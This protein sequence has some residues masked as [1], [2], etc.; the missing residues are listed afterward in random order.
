MDNTCNV[1]NS[2][3][4]RVAKDDYEI[5]FYTVSNGNYD[6]VQRLCRRLVD[7]EM[8]D[9]LFTAEEVRAAIVNHGQS[10]KRFKLGETIQYTPDEVENILMEGVAT[11]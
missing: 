9:R 5:T 1:Y 11:K 4:T 7:G 6:A 8:P 2:F 3:R 10:D